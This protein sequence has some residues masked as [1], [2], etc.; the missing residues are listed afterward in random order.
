LD[1]F[2]IFSLDI[3]PVHLGD[4]SKGLEVELSSVRF[5][6][7]H[8]EHLNTPRLIA[9]TTGTPVWKW[10][11]AEPFG[12]SPPDENPDLPR[13]LRTIGYLRM[14]PGLVES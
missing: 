6:S 7:S 1:V 10:D 8:P 11:Q 9:D 5:N 13:D 12:V 3:S 4:G 2:N 14:A